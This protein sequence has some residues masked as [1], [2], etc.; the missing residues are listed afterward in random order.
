MNEKSLELMDRLSAEND[1]SVAA[2]KEAHKDDP[3]EMCGAREAV[4]ITPS[5]SLARLKPLCPACSYRLNIRAEYWRKGFNEGARA[6]KSLPW[7]E[8]LFGSV[9]TR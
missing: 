5:G 7:W 3:C 6:A 9:E 8:R 1:A 4:T 2:W